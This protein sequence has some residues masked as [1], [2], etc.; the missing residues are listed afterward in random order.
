MTTE[1]EHGQL[2]PSLPL[3]DALIDTF[4]Q[5]PEGLSFDC[6]RLGK[7]DRV[8]ETVVAFANTEGGIICT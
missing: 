6:K 2:P 3:D 1:S 7:L 4:L 8:L 5:I